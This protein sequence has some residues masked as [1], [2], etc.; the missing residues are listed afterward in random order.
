[1]KKRLREI[2]KF[3][4]SIFMGN[5]GLF[6]FIGL[7]SVFF[8]EQG[9][10]PN[11]NIFEMSRIVYE[12]ILPTCIGYVGGEKIAGRN[13]GILAA[14]MVAGIMSFNS[15]VGILGAMLA[16]PMG[17]FLWKYAGS[18]LKE[19][20]GSSLQMLTGNLLAGILGG[21]LAI[22]G[23]YLLAPAL[24]WA[25]MGI[26]GCLEVLFEHRLLGLAN[27]IIEPLKILFLNNIVNH[28]ILVPLGTAQ[29]QETGKS[30][31]FLLES[32][33]GPGLGMLAA[34][35]LKQRERRAEHASAMFAQSIGGIHEV[36]FPFVIVNPWLLLPLI[37]GGV[38]GT[39]CFEIMDAGTAAPVSPGS[40]LTI[41]LMSGREGIPAAAAGIGISATIAFAGT[42]LLLHLK[43]QRRRVPEAA[44]E[45][46]AET[47][48]AETVQHTV[49]EASEHI[50]EK[51][52]F[53]TED[54]CQ[55]LPSE[56]NVNR[57]ETNMSYK[58][59]GF[60]CDAGVG[61]SAMGA[62]LFRRK[63]GQNGIS[64]ID[65]QAY[66]SDQVPEDLDLIIC[67]KDFRQYLPDKTDT[68][69]LAVESLMGGTELEELIK[70]MQ[71]SNR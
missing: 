12:V 9:W 62:A 11:E 53:G 65:V 37:A 10:L 39:L 31:L 13:G 6:I 19:R 3:Y 30:V 8:Q 25:A 42:L 29:V 33:P 45:T 50:S 40:I 71:E 59:I 41:F 54:E 5:I 28:G 21:V 4:S 2:G 34:L 46:V 47:N 51:A 23:Y 68:Q 17:G 35:C 1:M 22:L 64:G 58:K 55:E 52:V 48:T 7:L 66:A 18:R 61:S 15:Q 36:Y 67:Q 38:A 56:K 32:N 24:V 27:V 60:V 63:L 43:E 44:Q 49:E 70:C 16:G 20:S 26:S 69:I 57:E 14:L